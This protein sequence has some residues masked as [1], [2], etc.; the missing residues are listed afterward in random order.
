MT[1]IID[2]QDVFEQVN[3][4]LGEGGLRSSQVSIAVSVIIDHVNRVLSECQNSR[5]CQLKDDMK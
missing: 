2:K 5:P 3:E 4:E 1:T